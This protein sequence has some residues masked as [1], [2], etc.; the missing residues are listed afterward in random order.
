MLFTDVPIKKPVM[1]L[2]LLREEG[3][4]DGVVCHGLCLISGEV[5][6]RPRPYKSPTGPLLSMQTV[7]QV[8]QLDLVLALKD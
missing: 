2:L 7:L 8:D 4:V 3:R 6:Y 5:S 1:Q